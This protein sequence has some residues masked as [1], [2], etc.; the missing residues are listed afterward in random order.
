[1]QVIA[2][3]VHSLLDLWV[4]LLGIWVFLLC[5]SSLQVRSYVH[6]RLEPYFV[7][8]PFC[9]PSG[10]R[11]RRALSAAIGAHI[12]IG[13]VLVPE[14]VP[15]VRPCGGLLRSVVPWATWGGGTQLPRVAAGRLRARSPAIGGAIGIGQVLVPE[16]VP[17]GPVGGGRARSLALW[18]S[19]LK[20]FRKLAK[21]ARC[22]CLY[23]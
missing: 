1:M 6:V 19:I 16:P 18:A 11:S 3:H 20:V 21:I 8:T 5:R 12:G 10:C 9:P 14:P 4:F 15:S 17:S 7:G 22:V 2:T 13:Q 23:E